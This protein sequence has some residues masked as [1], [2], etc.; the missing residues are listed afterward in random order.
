MPSELLQILI[1]RPTGDRATL[2]DEDR[3]LVL[4][5]LGEQLPSRRDADSLDCLPGAGAH[6]LGGVAGEEE[7]G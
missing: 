4:A 2:S 7:P 3:D 1:S 6:E 5:D